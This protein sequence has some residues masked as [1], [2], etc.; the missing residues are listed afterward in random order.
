MT[1]ADMIIQERHLD[2]LRSTLLRPDGQEHAAYILYGVSQIGKDPFSG[3][4]RVRLSVRDILPVEVWEITSSDFQHVSWKTDRFVQLLARAEREGAHVG[5]AHCHPGGPRQ[6]SDQDNSNEAQLAKLVTNR[7]GPSAFLA[8]VLLCGDGTLI[9]RLWQSASKYLDFDV[10]ATVGPRWRRYEYAGANEPD[11]AFDRQTLALGAEFT[12]LMRSLKVGV[13]GAGG[14]GSPLLQQLARIGTGHI[15][16]FDPDTVEV[17]NLNRLYGATMSDALEGRKKVDVAKREIERMGLGT[18][19][20]IFDGWI[21]SK[22]SRDA[23]KSMDV[24]FGCTDDHD[25]RGLLNRLAY[26]YLIP[27]IDLGLALR[28]SE[29]VSER[30]LEAEGRVTVLEPGAACLLCR[31]IVS[32]AIA[33]E[34]ALK[35]NNPA[36]YERRKAEAYVR[37]EGNPAPAV[38]SFTTSAA[39]MAIEE[40]IQRLTGFRGADGNAPNRVRRFTRLEDVRPGAGEQPCR[41]CGNRHVHGIGDIEPFVGRVG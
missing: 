19:V 33:A 14:T 25:G 39:T 24:I 17:S 40:L 10:I 4:P 18:N 6:F 3:S 29:Q 32:P 9:G 41:V 27:V 30:R 15:G 28:V 13:V 23:L 7:N 1:S 11:P 8:S 35:R 20:E 16:V 31:R 22:E 5:I 12:G 38:V 26:Y 34:E 36:E 37:G 21:G 2:Q